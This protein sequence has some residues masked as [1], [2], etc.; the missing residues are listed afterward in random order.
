MAAFLIVRSSNPG[1]TRRRPSL[2][3]SLAS[4]GLRTLYR[5][6][7]S[8]LTFWSSRR[9]NTNMGRF[10]TCATIDVSLVR[11]P[12]ILAYSCRPRGPS[13]NIITSPP[14]LKCQPALSNIFI[15]HTRDGVLC[16][17]HSLPTPTSAYLVRA[18][19][20]ID[21]GQSRSFRIPEATQKCLSRSLV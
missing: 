19:L 15:L 21:S 5:C 4:S 12:M 10:S 14:Y 17:Q 2:K 13:Q 3:K 9:Q 11:V 8:C 18:A 1:T 16:S 20:K 7:T 6:T